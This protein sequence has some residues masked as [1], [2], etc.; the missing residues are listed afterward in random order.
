MATSSQNE[1]QSVSADTLTVGGACQALEK[2]RMAGSATKEQC[3]LTYQVWARENT[4]R[5]CDARPVA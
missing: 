5:A 4:G 3:R 1:R 2:G